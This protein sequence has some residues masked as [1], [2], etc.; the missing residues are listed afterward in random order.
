ML[1]SSSFVRFQILIINISFMRERDL[2]WI[3]VLRM[4]KAGFVIVPLQ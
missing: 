1:C 4:K 3:A 2:L